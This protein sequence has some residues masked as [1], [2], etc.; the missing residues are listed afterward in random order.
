MG[1]FQREFL[2]SIMGF[3]GH[4][5]VQARGGA[6][7]DFDA[8]AARLKH[9]PGVT[10]VAPIIDGQVMA[11]REG[12]NFGVLVRGM[13]AADLASLTT[14]ST[15]LSKGAL[16]RFD[17]DSIIIGQGLADK[18]ALTPGAGLTLISPRGEVTAFGT[19]PNIKTYRI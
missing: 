12:N 6:L 15:T 9:V 13:R 18:L 1:G 10:R 4:V 7:P 2:Q 14:V 19:V 5:I 8:V 16:S 11:T 17:N 3:N